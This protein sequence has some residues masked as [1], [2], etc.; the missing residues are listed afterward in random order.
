MLWMNFYGKLQLS[1][2]LYMN[3]EYGVIISVE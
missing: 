2:G 1:S 3:I